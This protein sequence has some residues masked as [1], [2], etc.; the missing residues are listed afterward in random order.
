MSTTA[1]RPLEGIKRCNYFN[2][3]RS[4]FFLSLETFEPSTE[5]LDQ[6]SITDTRDFKSWSV[7]PSEFV[8]LRVD[9]KSKAMA[10]ILLSMNMLQLP[11]SVNR[12]RSA[13]P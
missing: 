12:A 5:K 7:R 8:S 3:T 10:A 9:S 4:S 2:W 6:S 13:L 1:S 11:S